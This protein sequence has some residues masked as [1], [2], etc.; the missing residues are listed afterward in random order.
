MTSTT[1]RVATNTVM[2]LPPNPHPWATIQAA[3]HASVVM[4]Q[5]CDK[6]HDLLKSLRKHRITHTVPEGSS[7]ASFVLYVPALWDHVS[8]EFFLAYKGS[9]HI[10]LTRHIAVTVLHNK[11]INQEF[12][13]ISYHSVTAGRD[14]IRELLRGRGDMAVRK[15]IRRFKAEGIPIIIGADMNRTRKTFV[16]AP[17]WV[18]HRIDAIFA[19]NGKH[20]SLQEAGSHTVATSS[21]HDTLVVEVRATTR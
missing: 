10:S 12:A 1:F 8:T 9:K 2:A 16:S 14:R 3:P 20:V 17:I 19:W 21:D 7:Y 18:R 15:Q 5:E 4:T 13:F 11:A 6:I